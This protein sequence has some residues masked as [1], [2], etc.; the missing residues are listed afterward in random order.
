MADADLGEMNRGMPF[1]RDGFEAIEH[2]RGA[3]RLLRT[4]RLARIHACR[5][6]GTR[7]VSLFSCGLQPRVRIRAHGQ[8]A[9]L[10]IE[11]VLES[12]PT[13]SCGR[14]LQAEASL[15][16]EARWLWPGLGRTTVVAVIPKVT[17]TRGGTA[18]VA[19]GRTRQ[20]KTAKSLI[21]RAVFG[22]PWTSW[23]VME[24]ANGGAG[25]N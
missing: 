15:V 21:D 19:A 10:A 11:A 1:A 13:A 20:E 18:L 22:F 25:G 6:Q 24:F 7:T 2:G 17:P 14:H 9:L 8:Q 12:P 4:A 5:Q 3:A 23:D 16:V